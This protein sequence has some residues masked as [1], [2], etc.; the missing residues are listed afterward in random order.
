MGLQT[1]AWATVTVSKEKSGSRR[2]LERRATV[3]GVWTLRKHSW[4]WLANCWA[5]SLGTLPLLADFGG[6]LRASHSFVNGTAAEGL[7]GYAW[8]FLIN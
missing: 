5:E 3:L 4:A 2:R 1:I 6:L 7:F 8:T